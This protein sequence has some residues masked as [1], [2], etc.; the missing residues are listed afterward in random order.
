MFIQSFAA[1][2]RNVAHLACH[3]LATCSFAP[4][5]HAAGTW[6]NGVWPDAALAAR[7]AGCAIVALMAAAVAL[8]AL[9]SASSSRLGLNHALRVSWWFS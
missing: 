7:P 1:K 6:R 4:F 8:V 3:R 2:L 5:A 9:L